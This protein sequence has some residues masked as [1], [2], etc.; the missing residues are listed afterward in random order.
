MG[1]GRLFTR[2]GVDLGAFTRALGIKVRVGV[3]VGT[4][5]FGMTFLNQGVNVAVGMAV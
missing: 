2:V 3:A 1:V 4:I 5:L